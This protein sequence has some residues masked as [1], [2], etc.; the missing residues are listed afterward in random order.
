ME[1]ASKSHNPMAQKE[2]ISV[3][4]CKTDAVPD[5]KMRA[6]IMVTRVRPRAR[7]RGSGIPVFIRFFVS[8]VNNY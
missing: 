7:V 8:S 4:R 6:S 1:K 5:P 3:V 2:R